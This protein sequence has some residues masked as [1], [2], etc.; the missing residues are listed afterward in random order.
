MAGGRTDTGTTNPEGAPRFGAPPFA[1]ITVGSRTGST[2]G[3]PRRFAVR[4]RP[5]CASWLGSVPGANSPDAAIE[6]PGQ[7][8]HTLSEAGVVSVR[9][10]G[11]NGDG[12]HVRVTPVSS[13]PAMLPRRERT[14]VSFAPCLQRTNCVALGRAR[15]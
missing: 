15:E 10:V 5:F 1:A 12:R 6:V 11:Q 3:A 13:S 7:M 4:C 14:G 9:S 8:D 2:K